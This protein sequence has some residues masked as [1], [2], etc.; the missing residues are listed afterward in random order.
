MYFA[1]GFISARRRGNQLTGPMP[2]GLAHLIQ[3]A[4]KDEIDPY[5]T[6]PLGLSAD[7]DY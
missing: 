3:S 2:P 6:D 4:D 1:H 7:M 5:W